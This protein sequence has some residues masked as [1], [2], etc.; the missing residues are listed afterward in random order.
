MEA[1][2]EIV[3]RALEE[4]GVSLEKAGPTL[5]VLRTLRNKSLKKV[6][7][8]AGI[9]VKKLISI[10]GGKTF[11]DSGLLLKILKV[12]EIDLAHF[13]VALQ[14][15]NFMD[16]LLRWHRSTHVLGQTALVLGEGFSLPGADDPEEGGGG[17]PN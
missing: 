16:E 17:E 11:P 12:L 10:E 14:E 1:R 2:W 4:S 9:S 5:L 7:D 15:I 3:V 6:A 8:G 13:L